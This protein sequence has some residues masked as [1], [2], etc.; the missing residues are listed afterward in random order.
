WRRSRSVGPR[1]EGA[2][3]QGKVRL[4]MIGA[5]TQSGGAWLPEL[6]PDATVDRAAAAAPEGTRLVLDPAGEPLLDLPMAGP[7]SVAV[8]PE[9]GLEPAELA[10]LEQAGFRRARLAA[11]ILRFETAGVVG[12]ALVRAR[13]DAGAPPAPFAP[14]S[15]G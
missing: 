11:N 10:Q 9:G 12:L 1:G 14:P 6:H 13:L 8:G 15:P 5:L 3:F 7:V 4:R 2:G